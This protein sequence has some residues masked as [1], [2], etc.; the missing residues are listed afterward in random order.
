[1]AIPMAPQA[2]LLGFV[3]VEVGTAKIK[4]PVHALEFE[5]DGVSESPGGLVAE[6]E[7]LGIL[8][9]ANASESQRSAQISKAAN[10]A[11]GRLSRK[12]LN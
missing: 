11:I 9:D 1:M 3:S 6:G 4:L 5:T 8:V 12:F 2:K 10:E 7:G